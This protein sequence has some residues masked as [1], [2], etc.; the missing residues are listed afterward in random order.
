MANCEKK[1]SYVYIFYFVKIMPSNI[2]KSLIVT[3]YRSVTEYRY[4]I[5]P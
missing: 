5:S 3:K 1:F 4:H 2:Y